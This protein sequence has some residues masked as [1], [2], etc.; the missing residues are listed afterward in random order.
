MRSYVCAQCHVEYYFRGE[1]KYLTFPW[2]K[3]LSADS[4]EAYYDKAQFADWTHQLSRAPMLKAQHP[5]FELFSTGI[6]ADRRVACADCHM[7]YK[8]EGGIK[9][10]NHKIQSPLND[11]QNSC[12]VCH[13]ESEEKLRNNVYERQDKIRESK[14]LAEGELVKAHIESKAAWDRGA[15]EEE[16]KPVLQLIRHAQWRW[17]WVAASNGLS[18]HSP[19]EAQRVL[20]GAIQKASEARI[21]IAEILFKYG[22][23]TKIKFPDISSPAK[24]QSYIGL[25]MDKLRKDK[26]DF[27]KNVV[28]A[29]D[30]EAGMRERSQK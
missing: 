6:H 7:P 20:A 30:R 17:D 28:P 24:A 19:V 3:G 5:D 26:A 29:W 2:D 14:L 4:M 16:M 25:D 1:G 8:S 13:R 11:V 15:R 23:A 10:T 21:L 12:Q 27:I 18:F 22:L 9:Y